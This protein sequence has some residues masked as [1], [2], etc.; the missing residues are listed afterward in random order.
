MQE[1]PTRQRLLLPIRNLFFRQETTVDRLRLALMLFCY[2]PIN[3]VSMVANILGLSGPDAVAFKYF[4]V[5]VLAAVAVFLILFFKRR[6]SVSVCL[7]LFAISSQAVLTAYMLY[8]SFSPTDENLLLIEANTVKLAMNIVG[9]A[10]AMMTI[11]TI[12]LSVASAAVYAACVLISGDAALGGLLPG[13]VVSLFFISLGGL[14]IGRVTRNLEAENT[15][16]K[17]GEAELLHI[18]RLKR[19]EVKAFLTLASKQH[20]GDGTRTL[21]E[22]LDRKHM[23]NLIDNVENYLAEKDTDLKTIETAFPELTPSE[24]EICRLVLQGKKQGEICAILKK[25]ESNVNSQRANVRRKLGLQ[26]QDNLREKL[27]ARLEAAKG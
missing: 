5:A 6:I 21:L 24:R 23:Q 3:I 14:W 16:L 19:D 18:L 20:P 1:S 17:K 10:A 2:A 4:Q 22:A 26:P 7:S 25:N 11:M 15:Q 13:F 8:Y 27:Q 9:M 12:T